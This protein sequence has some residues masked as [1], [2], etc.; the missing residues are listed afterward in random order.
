MGPTITERVGAW[1]A[2][3][4]LERVPARVVERVRLQVVAAAAA[5]AAA[6]WHVPSRAAL[7]ACRRP[8]PALVFATGDLLEPG[9]AAFVNAAFAMSL[10]FDDYLLSGHTSHSAVQV[11]LAFA[12]TID[13]VLR[14]AVIA[15][16][17]MG[18][19]STSCLFGPLN[20]QMSSYIHAAGAA[21]SLGAVMALPERAMASALSL[22][23]SQPVRCL[24]PAFWHEGAKTLTAAMPLVLGLRAARLAAAGVEGPR[25]LFEHPQGLWSELSFAPFPGL[26]DGL[27]DVWF[28]DT[29]CYKRF[30]GTSYVSAAVEAVLEASGGRPLEARDVESVEVETTLLSAALDGAGTAAI[31]RSPLDAN[32]VNFSL[33]LSV[34]AALRFGQLTPGVLRPGSL[35]GAE[36]ALRAIAGRVRVVH[37]WAQTLRLL[38]ESPAGPRM[39]AALGPA[40]L[41]RLLAQARRIAGVS[42]RRG[43][44]AQRLGGVSPG[45]LAR[46]VALVARGRARGVSDRDLDL[47]RFRMLQSARVSLRTTDR[48]GARTCTVDVPAGACGRPR[49]ETRALVAARCLDAFGDRGAAVDAAVRD[50]G[51][52]V[53]E[54]RD[55][56]R[57]R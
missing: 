53:A 5:A 22:A 50:P 41:A 34:A 54:L 9:D 48:A 27:G 51:H 56:A 13:E 31:D 11:P 12:A 30:P 7:E 45:D 19:L 32:A 8:G 21:L 20:G 16:E 43:R 17:V 25:D 52:T 4:R 38:S 40:G 29:L 42:G 2:G 36:P 47:E 49:D 37:D 6:P 44:A 57:R 33:R 46:L 3:L 18:R 1:A 28:C 15:N 24:V 55:A 23:L 39:L 35:A 10:D 26:F 14:A